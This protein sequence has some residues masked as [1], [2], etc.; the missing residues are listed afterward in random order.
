MLMKPHI[1][2][3]EE[4]ESVIKRLKNNKAPGPDQIHGEV[5]KLLGPEQIKLLTNLFNKIYTGGQMPN[6]WLLSTFIP[7]PKKANATKCS[8]HRIISLMSHI[9]KAFLNIIQTRVYRRLDERISDTQFGFRKGLGTREA[10]FSIQAL[11]QRARDVNADVFACFIDFEMTFDRV[12]HD[13]M[14]TKSRESFWKTGRYEAYELDLE[15]RKSHGDEP[16]ELKGDFC[17]CGFGLHSS[18]ILGPIQENEL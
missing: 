14:N 9:L 12:Q 16:L 5:L 13:F 1:I 4:V 15:V 8:D 17:V 6:Y 11:I 2:T 18:A 3:Q 7:L 10:L